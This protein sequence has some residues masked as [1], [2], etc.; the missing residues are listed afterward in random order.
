MFFYLCVMRRVAVEVDADWRVPQRLTHRT[1]EG[2]HTEL[3]GW[4]APESAQD[5]RASALGLAHGREGSSVEAAVA[6]L[7]PIDAPETAS[8]LVAPGVR[9][10]PPLPSGTEPRPRG[11]PAPA[12]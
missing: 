5:R 8:L 11:G 2:I 9:G 7:P 6:S 1:D 10:G 4:A 12:D 3:R